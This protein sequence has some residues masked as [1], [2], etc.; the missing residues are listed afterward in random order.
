MSRVFIT[1]MGI[2]CSLGRS[3]GD[4]ADQLQAGACGRR[5]VTRFDVSA[6]SYKVRQ[7]ATLCDDDE[8]CSEVDDTRI[9]D[10]AITVGRDALRDAGLLAVPPPPTASG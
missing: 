10:L 5:D 9:S 3:L 7:A 8:L 1:G 6:P 2:W 4:V